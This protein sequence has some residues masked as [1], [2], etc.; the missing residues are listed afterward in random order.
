MQDAVPPGLQ[1]PGLGQSFGSA[2]AQLA[3]RGAGPQGPSSW[4]LAWEAAAAALASRTPAGVVRPGG[5]QMP[6][7]S[8]AGRPASSSFPPGPNEVALP[9]HVG[10]G[11]GGAGMMRRFVE[12]RGPAAAAAGMP[13]A[14]SSS[15]VMR[16]E[17]PQEEDAEEDDLMSVEGA[18]SSAAVSAPIAVGSSRPPRTPPL[19]I[20]LGPSAA[21]AAAAAVAATRTL[22]QDS[23]PR[24]AM[25][26]RHVDLQ[27]LLP[28]AAAAAVHGSSRPLGQALVDPQASGLSAHS[29]AQAAVS[30][31]GQAAAS[32]VGQEVP[33]LVKLKLWSIDPASP[34]HPVEQKH[35][36]L[37]L[38]HVVLCSEMGAHIS[39]CGRYL[40]ACVACRCAP[41]LFLASWRPGW[42]DLIDALPACRPQPSLYSGA[43]ADGSFAHAASPGG[44]HGAGAAAGSPYRGVVVGSHPPPAMEPASRE[45]PLGSSPGAARAPAAAPL[46]NLVYELRVISLDPCTLGR[47][48]SARPIRAAHC[49]TSIQFSPTGEHLL[50]AYGRRHLSL[51]RSLV[52]EERGSLLPVHTVLEVCRTKDLE[53]VRE[54]PSTEDE[55]NVACFSPRPGGGLCYGTK[56]G[57]LRLLRASKA[58]P[59]QEMP[60]G[61]ISEDLSE[62][63]SSEDD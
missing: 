14:S 39:P 18:S 57:R 32:I 15:H 53:V 42:T 17:E 29:A 52:A 7:A 48:L 10:G 51:L 60:L 27:L 33:C 4:D 19:P 45:H 56:E 58:P 35:S 40:A 37:S 25:G 31:V 55:V 9:G 16:S 2:F 3:G 41:H 30:I 12:S 6:A 43:P 28:A 50:L 24:P 5:L 62:Y 54:L 36:R 61:L 38:H 21:A 59:E 63:M 11:G 1:P 47:V 23:G 44:P 46:S 20:D 49:L 8:A 22:H 26:G 34:M 13:S